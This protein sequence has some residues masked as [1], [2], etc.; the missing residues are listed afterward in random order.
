MSIPFFSS[1][2]SAINAIN[3]VLHCLCFNL[4]FFDLVEVMVFRSNGFYSAS[5]KA[6]D[7]VS[8]ILLFLCIAGM[9][10]KVSSEKNSLT[11]LL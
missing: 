4:L 8:G 6:K 10:S 9:A 5:N 1:I 7:S 11:L 2:I 3:F